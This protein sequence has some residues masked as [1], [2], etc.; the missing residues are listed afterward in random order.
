MGKPFLTRMLATTSALATGLVLNAPGSLA[1]DSDQLLEE[2]V[3]T[4]TKRKTTL[5]D[6]PVAVSVTSAKT[7][8]QSRILDLKDLQSVVPSL[9]VAQLQTSGNT[10]FII[11][12]FGNGANNPG[13]ESS[14][15]MFIDGVYRSR[16]M[17]RI[18]DLPKI[19]RVEVL[20]GPQSTLFGKNASAGVINVVSAAPSFEPEGYVEAGY[21]NY[22]NFT[23]KA[24]YTNGLSDNV[25]FSLSANLN[26]RDGYTEAVIDGVEDINNRNRKGIRGQLLFTPSDNTQ[27]R[28]IAD[29]SELDEVCCSIVN[30]QNEGAANVLYALGAQLADDQDLFANKAYMNVTPSN[31][32]DDYGFSANVS[33]DY[34]TFNLTS[35]TSYRKNE[36]ANDYDADFTSLP[37]IQR[38]E[39]VNVETFTQE[40]RLTSTGD[41]TIDWMIGGFLFK[42]EVYS[43]D[44]LDWGAAT[45]NYVNALAGGPA[46]LGVVEAANGFAPNTFFSPGVAASESYTQDNTSISFFGTLDYHVTENFTITGGLNYTRDKKTI[47]A[48]NNFMDPWFFLDMTT[49]NGTDILANG[50][51]MAAWND[52]SSALYQAFQGA[53]GIPLTQQTQTLIASGGAGPLAQAGYLQGFFP[54]V[55]QG[56]IGSLQGLQFVPPMIDIPNSVESGKSDDDDLTW[57]IRGTYEIN[58]NMTVYVGA[59]T[60]FKSSSWNLS[61]ASAPFYADG[62]AMQAA[63]LLNPGINV[64]GNSI[65][66]SRNFGTRF[67]SPEKAKVY[68]IGFKSRFERGAFNLA[69]FDQTIEGFQSNLFQ[70]NGFVL[71]NAGEQSTKGF[72]VDATWLPVDALTLTFAATYLDAKYDSFE[73]AP[74]PDNSVVDLS[75]ERPAGIPKWALSTSATYNFELGEAAGF[76]RADWQYESNVLMVDNI[77]ATTGAEQPFREI[78]TFNASAG[79]SW[80][81]G[82]SVQIWARNLFN[83]KYLMSAFPGVLQPGVINGYRNP[84]R[85][86]GFNVRKEF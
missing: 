34:E 25:A 5:Q 44:G 22:N 35:I 21:G 62:A 46:L 69:I 20:R 65:A 66:T 28:L 30:L 39:L 18:G 74:G 17:A 64:L 27:I 81:N 86:F 55:Q 3:V 61:R 40:I 53:F 68:E 63:G 75:N 2:I 6:T 8:E 43:E 13:I 15:G 51:I 4:A 49:A 79:L 19:E 77:L 10:N 84:T 1:Q 31:K 23:A 26:V 50:Q 33:H 58:D 9:R 29:Y 78:S 24:Y 11:R 80:E 37:I 52:P 48:I 12:G 60:G 70:G 85:T 73:N 82:L 59:S 83:D 32:I 45:R 76:V 38:Q 41:N 36:S 7:I 42:D 67:A 56:V 71:A 14:V 47:S 16:T 72:E 57:N 54:Q